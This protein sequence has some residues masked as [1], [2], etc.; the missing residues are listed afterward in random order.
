MSIADPTKPPTYLGDAT[1]TPELTVQ[2]DLQGGGVAAVFCSGNPNGVRAG[3]QG[4]LAIDVVSKTAYQNQD[5]ATT[6]AAYAPG[7]GGLTSVSHDASLS[8]LGTVGSPLALA[9][10]HGATL[11]GLG[12]AAS[13]LDVVTT[14]LSAFASG[15]AGIVPASGGGAVNY[16]R[17]DG[18]WAAPAG[19]LA[20]VSHDASL[21]GNGTAGTPLALA[22]QHD[23]TLTGLGSAVTALG[24]A[25]PLTTPG[26]VSVTGPLSLTGTQVVSSASP[27]VITL[28]ATTGHLQLTGAVNA[29][30]NTTGTY[31][32]GI[33]G[34]ADGRVLLVENKSAV[35]GGHVTLLY[36]QTF[37]APTASTRIAGGSNAAGQ[38]GN[39]VAVDR[40]QA[41]TNPAG[42]G[43]LSAGLLLGQGAFALLRYEAGAVNRWRVV[44]SWT[45]NVAQLEVAGPFALS[46]DSA[47]AGYSSGNITSLDIAG[48]SWMRV[49]L[50]ATGKLQGIKVPFLSDGTTP[51]NG[52]IV[53][54]MIQG[55]GA[56]GQTLAESF[57]GAA[58]VGEQIYTGHGGDILSPA[59]GSGIFGTTVGLR[60][61]TNV[62][63]NYGGSIPGPGWFVFSV[64]QT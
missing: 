8:G 12:S 57:S 35:A 3:T 21:S 32:P 1:Q 15:A 34:G 61:S 59:A 55:L 27:G 10:Q 17:A 37:F 26:P 40:G 2:D 50:D 23:T 58:A 64:E 13:A 46:G 16:L 33:T 54:L 14:A 24:L 41:W 60:Y 30:Q 36:E 11:T 62:I 5:G 22:V 20:A 51:H 45:P 7:G 25:N 18:T 29:A 56:A 31:L 6:W 28:A 19:G 42:R 63:F 47:N 44:S 38:V 53:Y 48:A 43:E 9:V 52:R 4:Q 49:N 39:S